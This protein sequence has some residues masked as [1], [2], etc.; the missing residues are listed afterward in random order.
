MA[1]SFQRWLVVDSKR[2]LPIRGAI[3]KTIDVV[4]RFQF[5][6]ID[7]QNI[8]A[9]VYICAGHSQWRTQFGIPVFVVVDARDFV[10]AIFDRK[11]RAEQSALNLRHVGHVAAAHV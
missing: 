10:A 5:D 4:R 2:S 6:A 11:V 3:E 9:N 8:V 7:R 1:R